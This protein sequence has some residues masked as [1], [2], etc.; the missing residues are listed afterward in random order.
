MRRD[1]K[2]IGICCLFLSSLEGASLKT[3]YYD[4]LS[5]VPASGYPQQASWPLFSQDGAITMKLHQT[6]TLTAPAGIGTC[7]TYYISKTIDM[8]KPP[9]SDMDLGWS[10]EKIAAV[11]NNCGG[12]AYTNIALNNQYT[13]PQPVTAHNRYTGSTPLYV[14]A[15]RNP[16]GV[17]TTAILPS[18]DTYIDPYQSV[19]TFSISGQ[20]YAAVG[21]ADW[22]A[23]CFY[24][25]IYRLDTGTPVMVGSRITVDGTSTVNNNYCANEVFYSYNGGHHYLHFIH[26]SSI[27]LVDDLYKVDNP[28][29]PVFVSRNPRALINFDYSS[30]MDAY[31]D[32]NGVLAIGT[33]AGAQPLS[34][35]GGSGIFSNTSA[36]M[37][38]GTTSSQLPSNYTSFKSFISN[39]PSD[40]TSIMICQTL[41]QKLGS[42]WSIEPLAF[43][44]TEP[45][46]CLIRGWSGC[47]K[48]PS[49]GNLY[50]FSIYPFKVDSGCAVRAYRHYFDSGDDPY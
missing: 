49:D 13:P 16:S 44:G 20:N 10:T 6:T 4:V 46:G 38:Y 27:G 14:I 26:T 47:S 17:W 36:V 23:P 8:T 28:A 18:L 39:A 21:V 50:A 11:G 43:N 5:N 48:N 7:A 12:Y 32:V 15:Q 3:V 37:D 29:S 31:F 40:Y 25:Y 42:M 30:T 2:V 19:A 34:R 24:A 35:N 1:L 22:C 41:A 33:N 45:I 9:A